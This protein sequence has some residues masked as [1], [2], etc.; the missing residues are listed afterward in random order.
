MAAPPYFPAPRA[1]AAATNNDGE[2]VMSPAAL[3]A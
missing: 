1:A 2:Y 3:N